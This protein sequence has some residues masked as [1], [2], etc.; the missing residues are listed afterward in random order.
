MFKKL[1]ANHLARQEEFDMHLLAKSKSQEREE[2]MDASDYGLSTSQSSGKSQKLA[3]KGVRKPMGSQT[4]IEVWN[5]A[6][7][8]YKHHINQ[9]TTKSTCVIMMAFQLFEHLLGKDQHKQWT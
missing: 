1:D 7:K 9:D 4:K 2:P 3:T 5:Y 6:C 8:V